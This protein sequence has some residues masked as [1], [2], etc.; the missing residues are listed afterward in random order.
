MD[1]GVWVAVVILLILFLVIM[2]LLSI[3][4]LYHSVRLVYFYTDECPYCQQMTPEVEKADSKLSF[5]Y[6][7]VKVNLSKKTINGKSVDFFDSYVANYGSISGVPRLYI[8]DRD[9]LRREYMGVR[10]ADAIVKWANQGSYD[11]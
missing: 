8:N 6:G 1:N 3:R 9:G 10:E 11:V 7:L 2:L 5:I 4:L